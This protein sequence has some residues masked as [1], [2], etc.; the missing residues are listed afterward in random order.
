MLY[1]SDGSRLLSHFIRPDYVITLLQ[2]HA[3]CLVRQDAQS[4][5]H[6]GKLPAACFNQPYMGALEH[7]LNLSPKFLANQAHAIAGLR[8]RTFI[9]CWTHDPGGHMRERYGEG[10]QRCE[11]RVSELGLK[12]LLGYEWLSGSE[13][14][15]KRRPIPEIAGGHATAQL[16]EPIY[17]DGSEA[18]PIVPSFGA[19]AHK[20]TDYA[21]E[22]ELR[23]EAVIEPHDAS[24]S[25]AQVQIAWA[26]TSLA[27]LTIVLGVKVSEPA[28][29]EI[30]GIAASLGVSVRR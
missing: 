16:T 13:F 11:L 26:L 25:G 18:I 14:P 3:F 19:T 4:D 12:R 29:T 6:D 27:E 30:G 21:V 7:G 28:A 20:H 17:S 10:G 23:V 2:T 15:P 24:V 22:A 5:P 9:M 8:G 1:H